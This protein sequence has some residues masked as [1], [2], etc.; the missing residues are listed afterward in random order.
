[1][2]NRRTKAKYTNYGLGVYDSNAKDAMWADAPHPNLISPIQGLGVIDDYKLW[3]EDAWTITAVSVGTGTSTVALTDNPAGTVR[4]NTAANENDGAQA[5]SDAA[6]FKL[7][8]TNLLW[9]DWRVNLTDDAT[10]SDAFVGLSIADTTIIAGAPD[11]IIYWHKDD[12]D[13]NWDFTCRKN[14]TSTDRAAE[15]TA[16]AATQVILGFTWDGTTA[17]PYVDGVAGTATTTN[18]PDDVNLRLSFGY[19]NGAGTAQNEGM[20]IDWCRYVMIEDRS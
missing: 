15:A 16:V 10:Q 8:S 4:V 18:V 20:D 13:T 19:L 2:A 11:D 3:S 9:I 5:Q 14:G 17:T 7:A 12:G 1:M 6:T